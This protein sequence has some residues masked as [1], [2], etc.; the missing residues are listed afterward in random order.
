MNNK[1]VRMTFASSLSDICSK[2][3]SFDSGVLK[4]CYPGKNRNGSYFEK[5]DLIRCL[6]S[7]YNCPVVCNYDRDTDSLGGHDVELVHSD[8]NLKLVNK[9]VPVG[10]IPESAKYWF[11]ECTEDDGKKHE[12]LFTEALIWKRQEAYEKIK[13][14]GV[15]SQSMEILVKDGE[16]EDGV[17]HIRDF[18]FTAFTLI[19]VEPCF[20]GA[21]LTMESFSQ[22]EKEAFKRE[23]YEMMQDLKESFSTVTAPDTPSGDDNIPTHNITTEGGDR[24]LDEKMKLLE[25]FGKKPE[26]L[27]F[28]IED[29]SVEELREKLAKFE[30]DEPD[31]DPEEVDADPEESD[32]DPE[33]ANDDKDDDTDDSEEEGDDAP[34]AEDDGD[35]DT[36]VAGRIGSPASAYELAGNLREWLRDAVYALGSFTDEW[37]Y[38]CPNYWMVDYDADAGMVYCEDERDW[39]IY[40][41]SFTMNGDKP[42][43]DSASKKRMKV[44]YVEFA[45]E[46]TQA[47][48]PA[49]YS[50]LA[51]GLRK[52]TEEIGEIRS[53]LEDL[54]AY[55]KTIENAKAQAEREKIYARFKDLA[56]T[57]A[58]EEL[59]KHAEEYSA[60][61]LE[62]K[63]YALRGR[64]VSQAKFSYEPK[65]PRLVVDKTNGDEN[66]PYGGI[67]VQYSG[68]NR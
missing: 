22:E 1:T 8:G 46:D 62:E 48:A 49:V 67:V 14:D 34:A 19:G 17:Y 5:E 59:K 40:G 32:A 10:V 23:M 21:S 41:F 3:A 4:I 56:G 45:G 7:M 35:D 36:A 65:T 2:N 24:I 52:K 25:E 63:C 9:T 58:F 50:I 64:A 61:T 42:V 60:E 27:D 39:K 16:N 20:E 37:G 30:D 6:P 55:K 68:K 51:E 28:S 29:L 66:E 38:T 31:D 47:E 18:E 12:Y 13:R 53:E 33:D 43:I 54:L 44:E 26:D 15:T 11:A 57:D